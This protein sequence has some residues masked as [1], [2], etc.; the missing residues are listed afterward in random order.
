MP[1]CIVPS[2][3]GRVDW[4]ICRTRAGSGYNTPAGARDCAPLWMLVVNHVLRHP[5]G[6]A[7]GAYDVNTQLKNAGTGIKVGI[8]DTGATAPQ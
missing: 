7:V 8:V 5:A 2:M 4:A 6:V 3:C 1:Y